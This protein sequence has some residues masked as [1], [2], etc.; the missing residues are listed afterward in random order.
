MLMQELSHIAIFQ[1]LD[2][3]ELEH[4]APR[5]NL[6]YFEAG[7]VI[8]EQDQTAVNLYILLEGEVVIS[9]KPYDGPPLTVAR[10]TPGGVFGWSAALRREKYTSAAIST[11]KVTAI[12]MSS[13]ELKNLCE[14]NPRTGALLLDHLASAIAQR[15]NS[16]H[17]QILSILIQG[18]DLKQD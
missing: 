14:T 15:L 3:S 16:T 2:G 10:I 5:L 11:A 12:C 6:C 1:G 17:S 4:I 13:G 18:M 7:D 9:Y 8:F